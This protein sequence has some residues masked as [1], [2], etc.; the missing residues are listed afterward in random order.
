MVVVEQYRSIE[1]ERSDQLKSL[2]EADGT[3]LDSVHGETG[4]KKG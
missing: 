3:D 2:Q 4:V 1:K